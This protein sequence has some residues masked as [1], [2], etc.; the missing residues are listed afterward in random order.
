MVRC[1][2]LTRRALYK[3][4]GGLKP[5]RW[6]TV[7]VRP[8]SFPGWLESI[9]L[10]EHAEYLTSLV[11]MAYQVRKS[12]TGAAIFWGPKKYII[13]PPFPIE[14][15]QIITWLDPSYLRGLLERKYRLGIILLRVGA[16]SL[17]IF[18]GDRLILSKTGK[19]RILPRQRA[20]GMSAARYARIRDEQISQ[21]YKQVIWELERR[22]PPHKL[23]WIL[24]GGEKVALRR[25][26]RSSKYLQQHAS[27]TLKRILAVR[28]PSHKALRAILRE[29][30][31]SKVYTF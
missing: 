30:F 11:E 31:K 14:V 4:L 19:R 5:D 16:Y 27:I 1:K 24:L 2:Q 12:E 7:Y 29:V 9:E 25:L 13:L 17:G 23:D 28:R 18:E 26:I 10:V 8:T 20:G 15:D 6:L 22:F 3:L 21:L